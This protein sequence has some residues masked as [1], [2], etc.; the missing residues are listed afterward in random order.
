MILF[1]ML[2]IVNET[3]AFLPSL[4]SS[5]FSRVS[6]EI[7]YKKTKSAP[8]DKPTKSNAELQVSPLQCHYGS[9]YVHSN[10]TIAHSNRIL[11]LCPLKFQ[12]YIRYDSTRPQE[13]YDSFGWKSSV[14]LLN[15]RLA[16]LGLVAGLVTE[17]VTGLSIWEQVGLGDRTVQ[18]ALAGAATLAIVVLFFG[19]INALKEQSFIR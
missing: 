18:E 2:L 17:C 19:R 3:S 14:E 4:H 10:I 9:T 7:A 15:G 1:I 8:N 12:N 6:T 13:T 16:M 5:K 11:G